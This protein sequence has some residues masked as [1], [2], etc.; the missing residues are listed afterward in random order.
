[1]RAPAA[2][3]FDWDGTLLDSAEA[4]YRGYGRLFGSY[5]MSFDR[6]T[7]ARTYCPDWY[8]TYEA[9]GLD[10]AHWDEADRRWLGYYAE[11]P[12][13]LLGEALAG[14]ARLK[15]AGL[16]HGLVTSGQRERVVADLAR[17]GLSSAFD[18]IVCG[19]D[20]PERKP[21]PEPL[22][23]ALRALDV[24]A[25]DAAYVGDSPEDVQMAQAAGV[26]S[27][28]VPGGYPNRDALLDS[29]PDIFSETLGEA[30]TRLGI[31]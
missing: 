26:L 19:S 3:L 11:E 30:L 16:A 21:H 14:L 31:P 1:M 5:A 27:V 6:D 24:A 2:V 18:T 15:R 25:A 4:T 23:R 7:F 8:R 20:L 28:A 10:R 13:V 29:R 9:M 17:L 12:A 22:R